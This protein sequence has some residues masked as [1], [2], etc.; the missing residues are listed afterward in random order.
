[1]TK[2]IVQERL[3]EATP[4]EVFE[5]WSDAANLSQWMCPA[6]GMRP[7]S[8]ELD[9]RVGG[10]FRIVMHGPDQDYLHTGEYLEIDPPKRLVF[11]WVS[12]FIPEAEAMTRVSVTFEPAGAGQ[13]RLRLEHSEIPDSDTDAYA[14][15]E[16]GWRRILE[17]VSQSF[18]KEN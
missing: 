8:V 17:L 15:H 9:F 4:E 13:T 14:G 2:L 11:T 6:E 5:A 18:A 7:A 1:M 3:I 10:F 12:D 16:S